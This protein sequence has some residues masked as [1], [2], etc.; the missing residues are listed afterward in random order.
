MIRKLADQPPLLIRKFLSRGAPT[1][2]LAVFAHRRELQ[3]EDTSK[4]ILGIGMPG[5][6]R[7][8]TIYQHAT[9]LD[10]LRRQAK[11]AVAA[12]DHAAPH[13]IEEIGQE[14]QRA[15]ILDRFVGRP[16]RDVESEMIGLKTDGY[17]LGGLGHDC[18]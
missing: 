18:E 7:V 4:D 2:W 8:R 13:I 5:N 14:W 12:L 9:K 15:G 17:K 1:R 16:V 6:E 3:C 10:G 11:I